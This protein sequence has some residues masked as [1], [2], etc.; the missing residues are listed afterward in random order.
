[1]GFRSAL[2]ASVLLAAGPVQ[3]AGLADWSVSPLALDR[4]DWSASLGGVAGG[5]MYAPFGPSQ[6]FGASLSALLLPRIEDT[7]DNGWVVGA[8]GALLAYHDRLAGDLYGD[9]AFEKGWLYVQTPYGR[10]EMGENDGAA[11]RLSVT[12]PNVDPSVSIDGASTSFFR[13]PATGHAVIDMFR[14]QSAVFAT[15][16]D[17]KFSYTSPRLDGLEV[18]GSYTPYDAHGGLPFVSRGTSRFDRQTGIVEGAADYQADFGALSWS[19]YAGAAF[20]HD[21]DRTAGH[22][23]LKDFGLGAEADERFGG[24]RI[25]F[26]G[27]WRQS[28]AYAFDIA[29]ARGSGETRSWRASTTATM[30]PWIAGFEYA[31]GTSDTTGALPGLHEHGLEASLGYVLN[32]N[33]QFTGGWQNLEFRRGAGDFFNGAA[34]LD[35]NAAYLHLRFHV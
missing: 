4:G 3:G 23:A 12:G 25:A 33:V 17:A 14:L 20:G 6:N 19:A 30:G 5:S 34:T 28:N 35:V 2:F 11:Y 7:L 9:R 26:G 16:N 29:D 10:F 31:G 13:D 18:S 1:M 22:A 32:S 21:D 24:V 8:R 27:A 15:G